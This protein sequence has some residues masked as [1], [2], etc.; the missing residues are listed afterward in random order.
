MKSAITGFFRDLHEFDWRELSATEEL[1][2]WPAAV[3]AVII[4]VLVAAQFAAAYPLLLRG[5]HERDGRLGAEASALR[6]ERQRLAASAAEL[7][8][9]REWARDSEAPYMQMLRQ[10]PY[11]SEIPALIDE[12]ASLGSTF[13]L[14]FRALGLP[15]E[16]Q[17][18]HY[19]EQPIEIRVAGN[20]HAFGKFLSGLA[21]LDRIVTSHDFVLGGGEHGK[22][23]LSLQARS[24]RYQPLSEDAAE[25]SGARPELPRLPAPQQV[26]AFQYAANPVRDPFVFAAELTA[27]ASVPEA[28]DSGLSTEYAVGELR[29]VGLLRHGH[30]NRQQALIRDPSGAV[31]QVAAGDSLGRN[32]A[33]IRRI[34]ALGVELIEW[35]RDGTGAAVQQEILLGWEENQ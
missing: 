26:D 18:P 30:S 3:K 5:L 24:Y 17:A 16:R 31:R 20:Y 11:E 1:G 27:D 22:L 19:V 29:L 34:T 13:G 28:D 21:A 23:E 9:F 10:L 4:L 2:S 15:P 14:Q 8:S 33:R 6:S 25:V 7:E 35:T 32:G 12:I